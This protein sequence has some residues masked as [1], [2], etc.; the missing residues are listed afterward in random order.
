VFSF[1]I[2]T[3]HC[4]NQ[5]A[6]GAAKTDDGLIRKEVRDDPINEAT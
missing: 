6:I 4:I 5:A 1:C 2:Y 3:F